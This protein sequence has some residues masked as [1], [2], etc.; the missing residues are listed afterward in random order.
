[1]EHTHA[2]TIGATERYLLGE[3]DEQECAAFEEH[4]FSCA[5][6]AADVRA[7]AAVADGAALLLRDE[8]APSAAERRPGRVLRGPVSWFWPMPMG[9]A[10][11]LLLACVGLAWQG[12]A[13]RDAPESTYSV[14][15]GSMRAAEDLV[16]IPSGIQRVMLKFPVGEDPSPSYRARLERDGVLVREFKLLHADLAEEPGISFSRRSLP[17]GEYKVTLRGAGG[18]APFAATFGFSLRYRGD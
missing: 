1:M 16:E 11:A 17:P 12:L 6:C 3:L 8:A 14:M 9:A 7:A 10:A 4:Y 15:L 18:E 2:V 5:E 13:L